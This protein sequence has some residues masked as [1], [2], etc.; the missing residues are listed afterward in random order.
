MCRIP[1]NNVVVIP[2]QP[3]IQP[4]FGQEVADW[5]LTACRIGAVA[6]TAISGVVFFA[7]DSVVALSA[8]CVSLLVTVGLFCG[9]DFIFNSNNYVPANNWSYAPPRRVVHYQDPVHIVHQPP[10]I[11]TTSS[12][13]SSLPSLISVPSHHSYTTSSSS[14][15]PT[16]GGFDLAARPTIGSRHSSLPMSITPAISVAPP[17]ID[18]GSR[19]VLGRREELI[20]QPVVVHRDPFER[21]ELGS[22][23][24]G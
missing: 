4:T 2:Q 3:V 22:R 24:S 15:L 20:G 23:R 11:H 9:W 19:S 1:N 5:A 6:V 17:A 16:F 12:S 7:T 10:V 18:F 14:A 8:A 13:F 21:A